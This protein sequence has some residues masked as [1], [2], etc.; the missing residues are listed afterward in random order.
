MR[1]TDVTLKGGY[2]WQRW[3]NTSF[4]FEDSNDSDDVSGPAD[5]GFRGFTIGV[6]IKR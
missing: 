4:G 2:E 5:A 3:H 6:E 1:N